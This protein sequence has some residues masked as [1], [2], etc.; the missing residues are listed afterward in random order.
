M[1][2]DFRKSKGGRKGKCAVSSW[3]R[4]STLY[5][6]DSERFLSRHFRYDMDLNKSSGLARRPP[7]SSLH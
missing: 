5:S 4:Y 1:E 3:V 6:V 2:A 7:V